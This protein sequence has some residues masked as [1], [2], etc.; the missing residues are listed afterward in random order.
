MIERI[1]GDEQRAVHVAGGGQ[2]AQH[3]VERQLSWQQLQHMRHPGLAAHCQSPV[4]GPADE[5]HSRAQR[6]CPQNV[7]SFWTEP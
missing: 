2:S 1:G 5:H 6:Q 4:D 3:L 7:G